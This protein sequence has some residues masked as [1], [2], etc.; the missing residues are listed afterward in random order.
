[1]DRRRP[2]APEELEIFLNK[3]E[4]SDDTYAT[5]E[6][7]EYEPSSEH[8]ESGDS[9]I[10]MSG[11]DDKVANNDAHSESEHENIQDIESNEP[12][13]PSEPH[14]SFVPKWKVSTKIKCGLSSV[15]GPHLIPVELFKKLFPPSLFM[16]IAQCTNERIRFYKQ[17]Q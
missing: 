12:N 15:I 2:L 7:S 17:M 4:F 13:L 16:H 6:D 1:M 3:D 5:D 8:S 10:D 11:A 9:T 14:P